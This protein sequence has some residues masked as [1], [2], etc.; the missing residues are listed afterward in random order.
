MQGH[1]R[2]PMY[3]V[4][5]P[6]LSLLGLGPKGQ[7]SYSGNIPEGQNCQAQ[8]TSFYLIKDRQQAGA[9]LCQAQRCKVF[10]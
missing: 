6:S 1:E 9:E 2:A 4:G 3:Q 7:I 10:F 5:S 8:I